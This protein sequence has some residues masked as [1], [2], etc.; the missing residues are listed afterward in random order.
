MGMTMKPPPS[1][2]E[3]ENPQSRYFDGHLLPVI[4]ETGGKRKRRKTRKNKR[5]SKRKYSRRK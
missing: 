3:D 1:K 5:K 2:D 4:N